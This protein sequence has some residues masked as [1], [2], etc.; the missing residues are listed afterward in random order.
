MAPLA[1]N[2]PVLIT[3]MHH[4]GTSLVARILSLAGLTCGGRP[5]RFE[6]PVFA[7]ANDTILLPRRTMWAALDPIAEC[8]ITSDRI[9]AFIRHIADYCATVGGRRLGI[10]DPRL[11]LLLGTYLQLFPSAVVVCVYRDASAIARSLARTPRKS[12]IGQ[13][14][15]DVAYWHALTSVYWRRLENVIATAQPKHHIIKYEDLCANPTEVAFDLVHRVNLCVTDQL[16]E[17]LATGIRPSR[18]AAV[19]FARS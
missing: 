17:F 2:N 13:N 10:K 14:T 9:D 6:S 12:G 7:F 4:S 16:A 18:P 19:P 8:E 5:P 11:C 1:V 15:R 3:G